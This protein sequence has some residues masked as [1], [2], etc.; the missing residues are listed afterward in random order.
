[1]NDVA[2]PTIRMELSGKK[3]LVL[4]LGVSGLSM[5]RWLAS[6]GAGVRVADTRAAPPCG[7]LLRREL[8]DVPLTT[9]AFRSETFADVDMIAISPGVALSEPL[10][11]IARQG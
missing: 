7:A 10:V 11:D 2:P 4:G 1:M 9:G 8:P 5:A 6:R 3:A